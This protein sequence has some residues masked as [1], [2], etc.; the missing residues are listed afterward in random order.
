MGNATNT[1]AAKGRKTLPGER[2]L[3]KARKKKVASK[4]NPSSQ[5]INRPTDNTLPPLVGAGPSRSSTSRATKERS[6][7]DS[8]A[9][10]QVHRA[11]A[12]VVDANNEE[13]EV[14]MKLGDE[15]PICSELT[16]AKVDVN[17]IKRTA[18]DNKVVVG[19][20][21]GGQ[22]LL[23]EEINGPKRRP[24]GLNRSCSVLATTANARSASNTATNMATST[25]RDLLG[26]GSSPYTTSKLSQ[27]RMSP[28]VEDQ[29]ERVQ[30]WLQSQPVGEP[31]GEP[32][33]PLGVASNNSVSGEAASE[34][35]SV[36]HLY[37]LMALLPI[38]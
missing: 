27:L 2:G 18:V 4:T 30:R 25:S 6:G 36:M 37:D 15:T 32:M 12:S 26:S 23:R 13:P 5:A 34:V 17:Q 10:K 7:D 38:Q 22:V 19:G 35:S 11:T 33:E 8:A 1:P 21:S 24:V 20:G 16:P 29:R 3:R 14:G 9:E 28:S 31:G